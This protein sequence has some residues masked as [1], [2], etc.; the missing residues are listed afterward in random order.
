LNEGRL[1]G[2]ALDC[3]DP[4]PPV[5]ESPLWTLPNVF[6]TPHTGG[7]TTRYEANVI[8]ILMD[9]LDR[10]WRGEATLRNQIV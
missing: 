10:L 7:E 4:E 6:L 5:A 9:N 2:A 3:T 1:A 8:E